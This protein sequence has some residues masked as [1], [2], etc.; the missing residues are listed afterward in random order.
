MTEI[1]IAIA[2]VASVIISVYIFRATQK[3]YLE[4]TRPVLLIK[5]LEDGRIEGKNSGERTAFDLVIM[6]AVIYE[7]GEKIIETEDF[8]LRKR[9]LEKGDS[10]IFSLPLKEH[11]EGNVFILIVGQGSNLRTVR[12]V[13]YSDASNGRWYET[14]HATEAVNGIHRIIV[15]QAFNDIEEKLNA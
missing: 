2:S 1:I 5:R 8:T 4:Q 6:G 14:D 7:R 9:E 11:K 15:T 13:F 10:K 12:K 3:N